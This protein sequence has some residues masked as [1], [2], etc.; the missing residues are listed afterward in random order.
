MGGKH[1][2]DA[3]VSF[4][5]VHPAEIKRP[6]NKVLSAIVFIATKGA[7]LMFYIFLKRLMNRGRL[8]KRA[9]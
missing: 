5:G 4:L 2:H 3:A 8:Q 7:S 9:L 1:A 6:R